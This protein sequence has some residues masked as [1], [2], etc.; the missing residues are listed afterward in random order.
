M[1]E[2]EDKASPE[3][4]ESQAEFAP[5]DTVT[6]ISGGPLMCVS[7]IR[8]ARAVCIWFAADERL[9]SAEIPLACIEP[10]GPL[11][12][13]GGELGAEDPEEEEAPAG[14]KKKKKKKHNDD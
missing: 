6:L 12:F 10:A 9:C 3:A 4:R 14:K 1:T 7:E 13:M 8:G 2:I 11:D 5:G